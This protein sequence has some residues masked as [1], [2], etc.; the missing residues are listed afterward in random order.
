MHRR[1]DFC[2]EGDRFNNGNGSLMRLAP[3]PIVFR[4]KHEEAMKYS[5]LSSRT[6][7]NGTEAKECCRLLSFILT[8]L[9]KRTKPDAK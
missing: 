8:S 1:D 9:Y 7:H 5:E 4:E 6:T 3:I 2:E